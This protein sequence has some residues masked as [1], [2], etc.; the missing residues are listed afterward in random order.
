MRRKDNPPLEGYNLTAWREVGNR[1]DAIFY[2]QMT[3]LDYVSNDN[4]KSYTLTELKNAQP[5]TV[6]IS[7]DQYVINFDAPNE[8]VVNMYSIHEDDELVYRTTCKIEMKLIKF[9]YWLAG[10]KFKK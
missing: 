4:G 1:S 2:L 6:T 7:L 8:D 5:H 9:F 10:V 3:W